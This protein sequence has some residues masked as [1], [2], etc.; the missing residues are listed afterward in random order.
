MDRA[1]KLVRR[2][3]ISQ[4]FMEDMQAL[5]RER[6]KLLQFRTMRLTY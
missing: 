5:I 4:V 3:Q 1:E 6:Q 2:R